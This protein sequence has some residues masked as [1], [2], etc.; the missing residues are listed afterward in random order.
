M[1]LI[2]AIKPNIEKKFDFLIDFYTRE[3][4][5]DRVLNKPSLIYFRVRFVSGNKK[6]YSKIT[7]E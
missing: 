5:R 7:R 1:F 3:V 6:H 4:G 2:D